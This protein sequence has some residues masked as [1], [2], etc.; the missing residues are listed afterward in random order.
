MLGRE[1]QN[2]AYPLATAINEFPS[3][4][5]LPVAVEA[6]VLYSTLKGSCLRCSFSASLSESLRL[7]RGGWGKGGKVNIII[8]SS[9]FL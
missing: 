5:I 7:E 2:K 1:A 4:K 6:Q 8:P 3:T 9:A